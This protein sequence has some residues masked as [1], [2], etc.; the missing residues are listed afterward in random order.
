MVGAAVGQAMDQPGIAVEVEDDR[1]VGG[2]QAVE[3]AVGQAVRVLA[4][5]REL[6]QVDDVD[7]ADL[8]SRG[9]ARAA[10]RPPPAPPWWGCRRR[11]PSPRPAPSPSSL[12]AWGQ[13]LM[14]LVQCAMA[15]VH[16]HVLQVLLLVADDH[17]DVVGALQAVIGHAEQRV[18][19]RRQV[20]AADVRA[21]VQHD[22]EEAGILVREAVVVLPPDGRGDQQVERRDRR[23]P[24]QLATHGQPLGVQVEHRVD[25]VDEGFVGREEAVAAGEQIAFEPAFQRVLR[26]HLQDAAV[27]R[28]L[29]AVGVFGQ[30]VGQPELLA[31]LVDRVEPVRGVLVGAED[32]EVVHVLAHDVAQE[33]AQRP[34]V[35]GRGLSRFV[36]RDGIVAEV[37]HAQGPCGAARRWRADW[38]SCAACPWGRAPSAPG[39]AARWRRTAPRACSCAASLRAASYGP[40]C[41]ACPRAAPG[42]SARTLRPCGHPLPWGRS[43]PWGC[44]AR[45]SASA[46]G[47]ACRWCAPPAGCGGSP[48]RSPPAS[49]PSAGA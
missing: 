11:R 27:G 24:G 31:R 45:S 32:A 36:H 12:L 16:G 41:R 48:A 46:A 18:D 3:V 23:P 40:G 43:S 15:C 34:G 37:R 17:V 35:L 25:D 44:A 6:E 4:V 29:A 1:L 21:L 22:V 10:A 20:D 42:G 49:R 39:A 30:V 2:E 13:M 9:S 14:P 26:E 5:G 28:Q 38:R 7:E 33:A 47:W 8:Q 19:V